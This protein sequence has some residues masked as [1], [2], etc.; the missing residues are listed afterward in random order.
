MKRVLCPGTYDPVTIGHL[1]IISRCSAMF[2]EVIVAVV[3][4][5]YRKTTLFSGRTNGCSSCRS[6]PS[7][8]RM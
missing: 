6:P 8:C 4:D 7:I 3:D 1:D 2:D 5:S